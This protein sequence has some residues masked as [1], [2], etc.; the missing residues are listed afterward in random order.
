L[1]GA[2]KHHRRLHQRAPQEGRAAREAAAHPDR[3]G[4]RLLREGRLMKGL[5]I[6]WTLTIWYGLVLATVLAVFGGA[7]YVTI[8]HELLAR[9]DVGLG[10]E[11]DEIAEDIQAAKDWSRL[12]EQLRRR[13]ARHEVYEFQVGRAEGGLIF[14]SDDIRPRH[15]PVPAIPGSLKHLDFESVP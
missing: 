1:G 11:L 12:S 9:A 13:F 15:F 5:S 10:A 14:Q 6:R 7:V 8:R 2:D 4:R 3:P